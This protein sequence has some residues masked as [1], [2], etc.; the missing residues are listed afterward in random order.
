MKQTK[1]KMILKFCSIMI[2]VFVGLQSSTLFT[3][4]FAQKNLEKLLVENYWESFIQSYEIYKFN[5]DGTGSVYGATPAL[6]YD[7]EMLE[8]CIQ[9]SGTTHIYEEYMPDIDVRDGGIDFTYQLKDDSIEIYRSDFS[10]SFTVSYVKKSQNIDWDL[11]IY[12]F[13]PDESGFFYET[14]F[15]DEYGYQNAMY[16]VNTNIKTG[17]LHNE[18]TVRLNGETLSF[19]VPPRIINNRT[20]VPMRAIFEKLGATVEWNGETQTIISKKGD[21]TIILAIDDTNMYVNDEVVVL[22]SPA[23]LI[24]SR[25]L[26]PVRAISEAFAL[27]VDWKDDSKTVVISS[28]SADTENSAPAYDENYLI[29]QAIKNL[30]LPV[31]NSITHTITTEFLP[32]INEWV[33]RIYFYEDGKLKAKYTWCLETDQ[34]YGGYSD[35]EESK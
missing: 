6:Y 19:D 33:A 27:N 11:G 28:T 21:T 12:E 13:L 2:T 31:R 5:S 25:T 30:D 9:N 23:C 14:D 20:M 32:A 26:V 17:N 34:H 24:D 18:I 1:G 15:Y 16:L 7:K 29:E 3:I 10:D 22:D 8:Y 35:F 4:C